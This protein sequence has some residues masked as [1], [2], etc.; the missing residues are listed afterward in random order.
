M[1]IP[2][3]KKMQKKEELKCLIYHIS[4]YSFLLETLHVYHVLEQRYVILLSNSLKQE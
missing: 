4:F 1:E 2:E 3:E